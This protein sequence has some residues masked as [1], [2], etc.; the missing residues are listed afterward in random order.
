MR[1]SERCMSIIAESIDDLIGRTPL[2]RLTRLSKGLGVDLLAKLEFLTPSGSSLDRVVLSMLQAAEAAGILSPGTAIV[3][4]TSGNIAFS[5]A[6]LAVP[7]GYRV[8]LV[9]P[10]VLPANRIQILRAMGAEVILSPA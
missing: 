7:R 6:T 4:A 5:L 10:D 3:E 8:I 9:M 2:L 1:T